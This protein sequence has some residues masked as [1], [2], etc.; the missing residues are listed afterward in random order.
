MIGD[1][2]A[3]PARRRWIK[4]AIVALFV[5]ALVA[6]FAFGGQKYLT[7][8][9]IK[10]NRDLL[11]G[12]TRDHQLAMI[13]IA[14]VVYVACVALSLPGAS[15]LSLLCGFLFGRWIGTLVIVVATTVGATLVGKEAAG[16]KEASASLQKSIDAEVLTAEQRDSFAKPKEKAPA[17]E[18]APAKGK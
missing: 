10:A 8:E 13:G 11:Q 14:L 2:P 18:A 7:L 4:I 12:Y 3:N 6:F 1:V 17:A 5:G 9:T 16:Y 15:I